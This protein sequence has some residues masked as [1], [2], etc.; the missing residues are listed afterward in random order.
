[1]SHSSGIPTS[2]AL[3]DTFGEANQNNIRLI[4]VEIQED[5]CVCTKTVES[6]G[7]FEQDLEVIPSFLEKDHAC[8]ILAKTDTKSI[9]LSGNNWVFMSY[10]P[11]LAKVREKMTYA[12]TRSNL[13]KEL[14]SSHFVDEIH[15]AAPGDFTKKG[16]Q[17]HKVHQESSAPL[18]WEEQQRAD[19]REGGLFVGGGGMYVHG[20]AF[21]VE[22]RAMQAIQEFCNNKVNYVQLAINI[23]D[24][25]VVYSTSGSVS[26]GDLDQSIPGDEPR[27]HFYR[28]TH[29]H[30]G[31]NLDS[32]IYIFSC[33]DGS[34]GTKS[35]PVRM[36]MLYSSSKANV[37]SLIT[38]NNVKIDLKLEINSASELSQ[39][40]I[41]N[42]LHPPKPEEKKAFSKPARPGAGARK[43]IK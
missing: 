15:S 24:E 13:K 3:I 27:F 35:A 39:S 38:K 14:G 37:E 29:S 5:Q 42:E 41:D 33:P 4:K 30:D 34:S 1:M 18:T 43:L 7:S 32:I 36:R 40:S 8:Y 31:D 25:K 20:I 28:Y 12:S 19:E 9:E 23:A 2:K 10:V 11:D 6:S 16:Y 26:I 17:A 22:E 21:P